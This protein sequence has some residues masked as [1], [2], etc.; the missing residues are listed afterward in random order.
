MLPP[1]QVV[2]EFEFDNSLESYLC[3]K[4][5]RRIHSERDLEPVQT[6]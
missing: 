4:D 1:H 5:I 3:Q 6:N 2:S